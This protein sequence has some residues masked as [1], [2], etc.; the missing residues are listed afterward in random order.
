MDNY[1]YKVRMCNYVNLDTVVPISISNVSNIFGNLEFS[2]RLKIAYDNIT[3][4]IQSNIRSLIDS[5]ELLQDIRDISDVDVIVNNTVGYI[6]SKHTYFLSVNVYSKIIDR[7]ITVYYIIGWLDIS[8]VI[9]N[10]HSIDLMF[11]YFPLYASIPSR[12]SKEIS[13]SY[14]DAEKYCIHLL[15]QDINCILIRSKQ[16]QRDFLIDFMNKIGLDSSLIQCVQ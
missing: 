13:L 8:L 6:W 3:E 2:D 12:K 14:K 16:Q 11:K 15:K 10:D 4:E 9:I 7:F 1:R 5:G